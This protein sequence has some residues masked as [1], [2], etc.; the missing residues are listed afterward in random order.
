MTVVGAAQPTPCEDVDMTS[1]ETLTV[2]VAD[3]LGRLTL[4]QPHKLNPL[5]NDAL[6]EVA[7]AAQWMDDNG[8]T[9]VIVTGAGD[10]AFCAGFD[11]TQFAQNNSDGTDG[12]TLG[13]RMAD[14]LESMDAVSVAAI[15]GHCIGGG[16]VLAAACDIRIAAENTNFAIPEVDLGI[17]LAWGGI[18]RLVREIGPALTKELVMTC[19]PF[20]AQEALSAGFL[21]KVVPTEGLEDAA[22]AMAAA[23]LKRPQRILRTTKRQVH[24]AIEDMASTRDGWAGS[25]ALQAALTDPEARASARQYLDDRGHK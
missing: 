16:L 9:V 19:R 3:G 8:A 23:L 11:L 17:P 4:N 20:D 14:A 1:F 10:R 7:Q 12:A 25:I 6:A 18:P 22:D 2:S 13:F 24:T 15:H 5:G 21:N